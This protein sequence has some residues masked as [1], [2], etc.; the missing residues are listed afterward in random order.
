MQDSGSTR[1]RENKVFRRYYDYER[2]RSNEREAWMTNTTPII[3]ITLPKGASFGYTKSRPQYRPW[4]LLIIKPRLGSSTRL[5]VCHQKTL[6]LTVD[7]VCQGTRRSKYNARLYEVLE[8]HEDQPETGY[9]SKHH[10]VLQTR[11]VRE[12]P[13]K[14]TRTLRRRATVYVHEGNFVFLRVY[15]LNRGSEPHDL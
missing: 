9:L 2:R 12:F 4:S 1:L 3:N 6:L 14:Q 10:R 11:R 13:Q 5:F 15:N 8:V 7:I